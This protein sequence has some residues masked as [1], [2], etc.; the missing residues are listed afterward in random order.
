MVFVK[1]S[2]I[3]TVH[4][5]EC[6]WRDLPLYFYYSSEFMCPGPLSLCNSLISLHP[7]LC[8]FC[9]YYS[10]CLPV[11]LS[12]CMPL[13]LLPFHYLVAIQPFHSTACTYKPLLSVYQSGSPASLLFFFPGFVVAI[14]IFLWLV[15]CTLPLLFAHFVLFLFYFVRF[16]ITCTTFLPFPCFIYYYPTVQSCLSHVDLALSAPLLSILYQAFSQILKTG[17]PECMFSHKVIRD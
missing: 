7:S 5:R 2:I 17:C 9:F 14:N 3:G 6:S 12:L 15:I 11:L 10:F 13:T 4:F 8:V 16:I 1:V